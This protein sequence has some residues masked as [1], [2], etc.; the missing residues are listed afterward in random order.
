MYDN[1]VFDRNATV[2]YT[3]R[4]GVLDFAKEFSLTQE[5]ALEVSDHMPVWAE[6]SVYEGGAA[7]MVAGRPVL[8]K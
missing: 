8:S 6:F 4:S 3:G 5:Q 1:I 7:P 2:E